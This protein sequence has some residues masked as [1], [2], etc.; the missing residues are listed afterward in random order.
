MKPRDTTELVLLN[1][2]R[3]QLRRPE[4][5]L[6]EDFFAAGGTSL[7]AVRLLAEVR[8]RTGVSLPLTAIASASTVEAMARLLR[9]G[10]AEPAG[11]PVVICAG[12]AR[13]VLVCVHPL[14]GSV[15]W[16]RHLADALPAGQACVGMQARALDPRLSPDADIP[17]MARNYLAELATGYR[18]EEL[19]LVGYS[20]GGLVAFEMAHQLSLAGTAPAGVV[21]LDT[22]VTRRPQP[23]ASRARLLW[24][25]V[26]HNFGLD[27][28]ADELAT[29][30]PDQMRSRVLEEA[31][32]RG[33]LPPGFGL[34][35]L[36]R[37]VDIYPINA[38]A[39]RTYR[40]PRYPGRIEL[41][42]PADGRVDEESLQLWREHSGEVRTH[43]I[44]GSHLDLLSPEHVHG[45]AEILARCYPPGQ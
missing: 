1:I 31:V 20:F 38:E 35:R 14:G 8:R 42:R 9:E 43:G 11:A 39:E 36:A 4:L 28:S 15:L 17:S 6:D 24:S 41:I 26:N 40:L 30:P 5:T 27:L 7:R 32:R 13:P 44:G 33:V 37:I 12:A 34:E 21:L 18:P 25:L 29:L 45:T 10:Y 19:L 3:T 16:Y 2:W 23:P 22:A